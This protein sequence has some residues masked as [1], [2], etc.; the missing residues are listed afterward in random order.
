M[1]GCDGGVAQCLP[2][3]PAGTVT[4]RHG[5]ELASHVRTGAG[6]IGRYAGPMRSNPIYA[7]L[8]SDPEAA[9]PELT[10]LWCDGPGDLGEDYL[11]RIDLMERFLDLHA[12]SFIDRLE[13]L[14]QECEG[15]R[16]FLA[17]AHTGDIAPSPAMEGFWRFRQRMLRD[18]PPA[19][20]PP[21]AEVE[22]QD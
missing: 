6:T 21:G 7:L 18:F 5:Q 22:L 20:W 4:D 14:A 11:F 1:E 3:S 9:W 12:A 19:D 8:E 2:V 15:A 13:S 17:G 10:R 16:S